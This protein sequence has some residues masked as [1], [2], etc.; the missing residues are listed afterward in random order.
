MNMH[1]VRIELHCIKADILFSLTTSTFCHCLYIWLMC[2][3]N[4]YPF[5]W[6]NNMKHPFDKH[7]CQKLQFT[8]SIYKFSVVFC[9]YSMS[10]KKFIHLYFCFFHTKNFR[11]SDEDIYSGHCI[12]IRSK[13]FEDE[14]SNVCVVVVSFPCIFFQ[15]KSVFEANINVCLVIC[16]L[17]YFR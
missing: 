2:M 5:M 8:T 9:H 4:W 16:Y 6:L 17:L 3:H 15:R 11:T 10:M 13:W 14:K 7:V 12:H 1:F